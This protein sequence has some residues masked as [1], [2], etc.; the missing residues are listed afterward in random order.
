MFG[1]W[2]DSC[3]APSRYIWAFS[4]FPRIARLFGADVRTDIGD[5]RGER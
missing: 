1:R 5:A 2:I 4:L 3:L